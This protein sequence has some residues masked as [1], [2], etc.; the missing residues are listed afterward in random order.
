MN[1]PLDHDL[2]KK[3]KRLIDSITFEKGNLRH[4]WM[5]LIAAIC[6]RKFLVCSISRAQPE[7][8]VAPWLFT[9]GSHLFPHDMTFLEIMSKK[10]LI[11]IESL[12]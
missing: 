7:D 4:A 8:F 11:L 3:C 9:W 2:V 1:Q 12:I 6:V 5:P 10:E